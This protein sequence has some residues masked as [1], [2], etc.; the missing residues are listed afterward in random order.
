M[1]ETTHVLL[2]A[3]NEGTADRV[4]REYLVDG[5]DR[6]P[7]ADFCD[8]VSFAFDDH[9]ETGESSVVALVLEGNASTLVAEERSQWDALVEEGYIEEWEQAAVF[10][11]DELDDE[12]SE[13]YLELSSRISQL[14]AEMAGLVYE[15]F[16]TRP[17][18]VDT[19]PD[20][21]EGVP[22]VGW[23][24]LLHHLTNQQNYS[25]EAELRAYEYGIEH[26]L[27]NIA[28]YEGETAA[29]ER[30]DRHLESLESKREELCKGRIDT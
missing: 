22:P 30:L 7:D 26:T 13:E 14:S 24:S 19:V 20:E 17:A 11:H 4:V 21:D 27:R 2:K 29:A 6:L 9:P 10:D 3:E 25:L 23:W 5:I 8:G 18:P 12:L 16:D 28:E 1:T 15:M